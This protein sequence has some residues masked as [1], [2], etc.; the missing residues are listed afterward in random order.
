M[1]GGRGEGVRRSLPP[2]LPPT[3]MRE[4]VAGFSNNQVSF[5]SVWAPP[6]KTSSQTISLGQ[7]IVSPCLCM[8]HLWTSESQDLVLHSLHPSGYW[9]SIPG[10][11]ATHQESTKANHFASPQQADSSNHQE[12][13]TA[14]VCL[15]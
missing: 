4:A 2:P 5:C 9:T 7:Q 1:F 13:I 12:F 6:L 11:Q 8:R 15:H 14:L 10:S 3:L